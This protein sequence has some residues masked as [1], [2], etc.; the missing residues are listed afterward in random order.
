MGAKRRRWWSM[1]PVGWGLC[2]PLAGLVWVAA[3]GYDLRHQLLWVIHEVGGWPATVFFTTRVL[4]GHWFSLTGPSFG[5]IEL[6]VVLLV[7]HFSARPIRWWRY[8]LLVAWALTEPALVWMM[9]RAVLQSPTWY[10][11]RSPIAWIGVLRTA[12]GAGTGPV[13][14]I[15]TRSWRVAGLISTAAL[16]CYWVHHD[17]SPASWLPWP[18]WTEWA[19]KFV[20]IGMVGGTLAW[21][22]WDQRR[23]I[24]PEWA[25]QACGYDLRGTPG[26]AVCP[27]C[28]SVR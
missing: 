1:G 6:A 7:L 13:L 20:Y 28:G 19:P 18:V 15:V 27:E 4:V 22:V 26:G 23:R 14:G 3:T 8:A 16:I 12:V 21:W 10:P 9:P 25:C 17:V 5:G 2:V 24:R 11:L